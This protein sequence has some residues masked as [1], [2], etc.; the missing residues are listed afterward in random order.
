MNYYIA[1][2]I[3]GKNRYYEGTKIPIPKAQFALPI[4]AKT[5]EEAERILKEHIKDVGYTKAIYFISETLKG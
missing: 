1:N 4:L 3:H 5:S 2:I